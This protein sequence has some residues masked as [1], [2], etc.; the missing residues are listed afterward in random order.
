MA[1]TTI[2]LIVAILLW[3][4][5]ESTRTELYQIRLVGFLGLL[6]A[7]VFQIYHHCYYPNCPPL[8]IT[9]LWSGVS[10]YVFWCLQCDTKKTKNTNEKETNHE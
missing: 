2:V 5:I 9:S 4:L 3:A 1:P 6:A 8:V 10:T 7:L